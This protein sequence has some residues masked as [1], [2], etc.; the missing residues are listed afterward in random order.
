MEIYP[1]GEEES[2][3]GNVAV[4][5]WHISADEGIAVT[6]SLSVRDSTSKEV[7]HKLSIGPEYFVD[8]YEEEEDAADS[9]G[10]YN[11]A[12]YLTMIDALINGTLTIE[13][14]MRLK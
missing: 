6:C 2:D 4:Y 1:G 8:P 11:L 3:E 10:V 14:R 9:W 5:L 7:A 12:K 13:V